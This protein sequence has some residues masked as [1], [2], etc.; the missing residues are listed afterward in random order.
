ME[1]INAFKEYLIIYGY[2]LYAILYIF[3][4]NELHKWI[5]QLSGFLLIYYIF[6][7]KHLGDR[8]PCSFITGILILFL[9]ILFLTIYYIKKVRGKINKKSH[10]LRPAFVAFLFI[11]SYLLGMTAKDLQLPWFTGF[12]LT[13]ISFLIGIVI[14]RK[15]P[16]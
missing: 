14:Y 1:A 12:I 4:R 13:T 5:S 8:T 3:S 10:L 7:G 9:I 15:Q 11:G 6:I 2:A 16:K